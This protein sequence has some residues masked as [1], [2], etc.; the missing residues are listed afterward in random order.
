MNECVAY[1]RDLPWTVGSDPRPLLGP[2]ATGA[3]FLLFEPLPLPR[4]GLVEVHEPQEPY[5]Q[6]D[7]YRVPLDLGV[8]QGGAHPRPEPLSAPGLPSRGRPVEARP[9][10]GAKLPRGL[11]TRDGARVY[12]FCCFYR[13]RCRR[14]RRRRPAEEDGGVWAR[15]IGRISLS[16]CFLSLRRGMPRGPSPYSHG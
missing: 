13:C 6:A 3:G 5:A 8:A 16:C 12:W 4:L 2:T 1:R 9:R 14:R 7:G 15:H 10:G 11:Q